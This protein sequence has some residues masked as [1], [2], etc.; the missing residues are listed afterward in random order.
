MSS[1]GLV[2]SYDSKA[3]WK[4]CVTASI[5]SFL[6]GYNIAVVGQA[7]DSVASSLK[8]PNDGI[9]SSLLTSVM[10]LGAAVSA[11]FAGTVSDEIGIRKT[12]MLFN[13]IN[14]L[15]AG[16]TMVPNT[17]T[18][19]IG[20]A[21]TG[22]S[23]GIYAALVP[24]FINESSPT[25]ISGKTG[26]LFQIKTNLGILIAQALGIFLKDDNQ[27]STSREYWWIFMFGLQIVFAFTQFLLLLL[28]YRLETPAWYWRKN[29]SEDA[30]ESLKQVYPE[31]TA[32]K[33][34]K[35]LNIEKQDKE[36]TETFVSEKNYD[37]SYLDLLLCKQ[38]TSKPMRLGY[39]NSF[40]QQF[41]GINAITNFFGHI[42]GGGLMGA[43][44]TAISGIVSLIAS[45]ASAP[46]VN[47][48]GRK[49]LL[50]WGFAGMG[51][52]QLVVGLFAGVISVNY[53]VKACFLFLFL[54]F[55][56]LSSGP[57]CWTYCGD[58]LTSKG[59]SICSSFNF[60]SFAVVAFGFYYLKHAI[61]E[62]IV[63]WILAG[64][65]SVATVYFAVDMVETK[66]LSKQEIQKLM[67]KK[68][69]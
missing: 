23:V 12:L 35:E 42:T 9:V 37:P 48:F 10:P 50:V 58:I 29:F 63:F 51:V 31:E 16:I 39:A 59:I 61:G 64:I 53:L 30:L 54:A 47:S 34:L 62:E 66:G 8:F 36:L 67:T 17:I 57:I 49:T 40:F 21:I 19:V 56:S 32:Q 2:T 52:C 68:G 4:M 5:G 20:R 18:F 55:F 60:V 24:I 26:S 65:C 3:V 1:E 45:L 22:L 43:V 14:I 33:K 69:N 44:Y 28:V 13:L 27:D 11:P 6:F 38:N 15:G 46:L 41:S 25:D 7:L